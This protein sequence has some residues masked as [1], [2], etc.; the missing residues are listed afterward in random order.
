MLLTTFMW[1]Y[2]YSDVDGKRLKLNIWDTTGEEKYRSLSTLFFRSAHGVLIF[3]DVTSR[4]SFEKIGMWM[5][6][7]KEKS[8][9]GVDVV[10]VGNKIDLESERQVSTE[11]GSEC[12]ELLGVPFFE[13]SAKD[14]NFVAQPFNKLGELIVEK[15]LK[16][17]EEHVDDSSDNQ[18]VDIS[19]TH[20]GENKYKSGCC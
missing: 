7:V 5:K 6:E 10:L 2:I 8:P 15:N 1:I 3:Y 14:G 12:A 20:K 16:M 17:F 4:E 19:S 9:E 13:I 11:E 18:N